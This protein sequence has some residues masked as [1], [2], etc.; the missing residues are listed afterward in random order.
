MEI[1]LKKLVRSLVPIIIILC[2]SL[3]VY[4]CMGGRGLCVDVW[5]LFVFFELE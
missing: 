3:G 2:Y 5:F 1:L 4:V